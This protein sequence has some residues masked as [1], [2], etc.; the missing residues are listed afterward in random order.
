[1]DKETKKLR[2]LA[3]MCKTKTPEY[4]QKRKHWSCEGADGL[5]ALKPEEQVAQQGGKLSGRTS[6]YVYG[7]DFLK[8]VRNSSCCS[9][10]SI[11]PRVMSSCKSISHSVPKFLVTLLYIGHL[12][13]LVNRQKISMPA[14]IVYL[15]AS[16]TPADSLPL[17]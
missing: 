4:S 1:M 3:K 7:T 5:A 17:I 9:W 13:R 2:A 14:F 8:F 10:C 12:S 16:S 11:F 6:A 15:S